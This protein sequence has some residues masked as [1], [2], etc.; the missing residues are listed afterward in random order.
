M[1]FGSGT[2]HLLSAKFEIQALPSNQK[3][4]PSRDLT[5]LR[6]EKESNL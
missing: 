3:G 5:D 1:E 2:R 6:V 4:L